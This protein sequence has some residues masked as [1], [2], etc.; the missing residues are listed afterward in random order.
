MA[1]N[2]STKRIAELNDA[3][4]TEGP[5]GRWKVSIGLFALGMQMVMDVLRGVAT[6]DDYT[7]DNDPYGEHD[8]GVF[9][10]GGVEVMWKIDYYDIRREGGSPDPSDPEVTERVIT[11]MLASEN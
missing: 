8:A 7:E 2:G 9:E 6:F 5:D 4:R 3:M 11:I 10:M 1:G